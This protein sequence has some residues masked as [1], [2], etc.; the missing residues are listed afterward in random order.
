MGKFHFFTNPDLLLTQ[1]S[2]QSFGAKNSVTI[3][4]VQYDV[5]NA[6]SS[7]TASTNPKIYAPSDGIICFQE[8]ISN[9]NLLNA[10]I[11][12]KTNNYLDFCGVKFFILK[13]ILK[14][15][16]VQSSGII[17]PVGTNPFIDR[18]WASQNL[19]NNQ[20]FFPP[21][22]PHLALPSHRLALRGFEGWEG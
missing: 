12:P 19:F 7:H 8:D 10:I 16:L 18:I 14:N 5:F 20:L 22:S 4:G 17:N 1:I 6:G 13:G 11:K 2:D 15:S 3:A 21:A 9:P